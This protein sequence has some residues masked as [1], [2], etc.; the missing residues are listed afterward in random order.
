MDDVKRRNRFA[1]LHF[2][3][4]I[5]IDMLPESEGGQGEIGYLGG[6]RR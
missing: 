1:P 4:T 5:E 2:H 6:G 3:I